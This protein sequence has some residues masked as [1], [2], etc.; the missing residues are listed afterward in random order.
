MAGSLSLP[1]NT[2]ENR[3]ARKN[4]RDGADAIV[5]IYFARESHPPSAQTTAILL[6]CPTSSLKVVRVRFRATL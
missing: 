5:R 6:A 3:T 2:G 4:R 1:P